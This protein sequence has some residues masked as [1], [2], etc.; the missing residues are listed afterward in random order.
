MN[1]ILFLLVILLSSGCASTDSVIV[2]EGN[3]LD[4]FDRPL[5]SVLVD[6]GGRHIKTNANGYFCYQAIHPKINIKFAT[7]VDGY[8][9]VDQ[10]LE[11][12][13]YYLDV[14]IFH[15]SEAKEPLVNFQ[16]VFPENHSGVE[17][18]CVKRR[19]E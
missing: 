12:G 15:H 7:K 9:N 8:N 11:Y 14:K 4:Q 3:V 1:K 10:D 19:M 17:N 18:Y 5:A 16:K 2:V 6:V 13:D